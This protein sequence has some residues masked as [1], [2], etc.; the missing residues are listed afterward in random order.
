MSIQNNTISIDPWN[1]DLVAMSYTGAPHYRHEEDVDPQ[2]EVTF[3]IVLRPRNSGPMTWSQHVELRSGEYH[4]ATAHA[5]QL[6]P[7]VEAVDGTMST[8]FVVM[9][10]A[11]TKFVISSA[12]VPTP[13]MTLWAEQ[14]QRFC[15][16]RIN[17]ERRRQVRADEEA[18]RRAAF[19]QEVAY[20]RE[21]Q[22]QD[23]RGLE[24]LTARKNEHFARGEP[25]WKATWA[26]RAN[27]S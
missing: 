27:W 2:S 20:L 19:E 10:H 21:Q 26:S 3:D 7:W 16:Q 12:P 6:G 8:R 5:T 14:L 13:A 1:Y 9:R 25:E 11:F 22:A 23:D 18:T 15:D 4:F 24:R 17:V